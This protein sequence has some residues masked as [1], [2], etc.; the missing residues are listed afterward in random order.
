MRLITSIVTVCVLMSCAPEETDAGRQQRETHEQVR[1]AQSETDRL[2]LEAQRQTRQQMKQ[3]GY[4][5][6]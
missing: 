2:L 1:S 3:Q 6:R 5:P 4:H